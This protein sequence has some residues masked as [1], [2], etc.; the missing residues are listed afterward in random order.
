MANIVNL[1]L[2]IKKGSKTSNVTVTYDACF[3]QCELM[4]NTT[5]IETVR[6]RGDDGI[7]ADDNLKTLKNSCVSASKRCVKRKITRSISNKVLNEDDSFFNRTDEVYAQV[8]L[9]PFK[10][11]TS[12]ASSNI[13]SSRF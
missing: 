13:I 3:T 11:K 1:T 7:L 2:D 8:K 9:V 6:L 5:F 12:S 10:P 4:D